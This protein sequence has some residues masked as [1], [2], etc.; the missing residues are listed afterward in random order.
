[1][2]RSR[3]ERPRGLTQQETLAFSEAVR[4]VTEYENHLNGLDSK[5]GLMLGLSV[6]LVPLASG[7]NIPLPLAALAVGASVVGAYW[8]WRGLVFWLAARN[9]W[10]L[11]ILETKAEHLPQVFEAMIRNLADNAVTMRDI[12]R[13]KVAALR[14]GTRALAVAAAALL[15]GASWDLL[16]VPTWR[17]LVVPLYRYLSDVDWVRLV[18]WLG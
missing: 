13:A 15:V 14:H 3:R 5:A 1:M 9:R 17:R 4:T 12:G 11:P 6:A 16:L 18:P 8:S 10:G 7:A 2:F